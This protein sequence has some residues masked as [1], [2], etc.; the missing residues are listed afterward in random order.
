MNLFIENFK[1]INIK[2]CSL[3]SKFGNKDNKVKFWGFFILIFKLKIYI[4]KRNKFKNIRLLFF[5]FYKCILVLK[6]ML[7]INMLIFKYRYDDKFK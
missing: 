6:I 2:R 5:I 1:K 3:I 4:F 7:Y